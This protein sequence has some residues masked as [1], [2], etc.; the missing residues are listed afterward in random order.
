M[1]EIRLSRKRSARK[2]RVSGVFPKSVN[3]KSKTH[4]TH[5]VPEETGLGISS[6]GKPK[7]KCLSGSFW[8]NEMKSTVIQL[9]SAQMMALEEAGEGSGKGEAPSQVHSLG[10]CV[11][12]DISKNYTSVS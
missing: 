12:F 8:F 9:A 6:V 11:S 5:L 3:M 10:N 4:E 1:L 2:I 7:S